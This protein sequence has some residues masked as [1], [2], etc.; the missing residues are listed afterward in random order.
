MSEHTSSVDIVSEPIQPFSLGTVE[1]VSKAIA[2]LYSGSELTIILAEAGLK[3][4]PGVSNTKWRRLAD[5]V[6][7]NQA[8]TQV[9]NALV[10]LITVA[11][12]PDRLL[13]RSARAVVAQDM[14][15]QYLSLTGLKVT[16]S[17]RVAT[18]TPSTTASEAQQRTQLLRGL[19]EARG[20]HKSVL[21]YCRPE[22]LKVDF[23]EAVFEAI[24]GLGSRMRSMSSLDLDGHKLVDAAMSG[25]NPPI[26]INDLATQTDRN[27]QLGV[28][29]LARG[30][31]SAFRN[32]SAHEPRV[33]W[34]MTEQDA[35]DVLATLSLVHRRLDSALS[36]QILRS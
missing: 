23:Y 9:G 31:F 36:R 28:A 27:E 3:G 5:V 26:K 30:L 34:T 33:E 10:A 21:N 11:F 15:N 1:G 12:K 25:D 6:S 24:K 20:T 35:L 13:D 4:D 2:D 22:L 14:V 19:L 17:G 8:K 7:T 32:P 18:T 29:S 16:D